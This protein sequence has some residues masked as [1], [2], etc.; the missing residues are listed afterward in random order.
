MPYE[1]LYTSAP[2]GLKPGSSGYCT[3][4]SSRGIPA[5]AVDLLESLSG[6]RHV[7]TPGSPEA[8]RN[9]VNWG[10]YLLRIS[11]RTEHVLSRVSDCELDYT[12]RSNKLA[13]HMVIDATCPA[14]PA[15][16]VGQPGW[17]IGQWD[18]QLEQFATQRKAPMERRPAGRCAAWEAA[19]GDAGWGGVLAESFLADP[20][21]KVFLIYR[22]D[23][24]ILPLIEEAIALLP[25][26]R[27]WDVTFATYGAA[28]P[29]TVECAWTGVV[30]G[31]PEVQQSH[32]FVNALRIDLTT[33]VPK[34]AGGALVE[35][36]RSGIRPRPTSAVRRPD[37][38]QRDVPALPQ[39]S[40]SPPPVKYVLE[41]EPFD[42][43]LE[44][45]SELPPSL[46]SRKV[47]GSGLSLA[48]VVAAVTIC[49]LTSIAAGFWLVRTRMNW[50]AAD[51]EVAQAAPLK[52]ERESEGTGQP[53]SKLPDE[54]ADDTGVPMPAQGTGAPPA[55]P[56]SE[57]DVN[58][59][60][61]SNGANRAA[62]NTDKSPPGKAMAVTPDSPMEDD[63][64]QSGPHV[65]EIVTQHRPD[66]RSKLREPTQFRFVAKKPFRFDELSQVSVLIPRGQGS[67]DKTSNFHSI[68]GQTFDGKKFELKGKKGNR[69]S[70]MEGT[71]SIDKKDGVVLTLTP[72]VDNLNRAHLVCLAN[73]VVQLV[74]KAGNH[75]LLQLTRE[76]NDQ[77]KVTV[78]NGLMHLTT[79]G[80][81]SQL[82]AVIDESDVVIDELS[83]SLDSKALKPTGDDKD[84]FRWDAADL[85]D[86]LVKEI[87]FAKQVSADGQGDV[88]VKWTNYS[89]LKSLEDPLANEAATLVLA[90]GPIKTDVGTSSKALLA[91]EPTYDLDATPEAISDAAKQVEKS[92][93]AAWSGKRD[94]KEITEEEY[95]RKLPENRSKFG[96]YVDKLQDYRRRA[97]I[98][99]V[100]KTRLKVDSGRLRYKVHPLDTD[101]RGE[102]VASPPSDQK[103]LLV[104]LLSFGQRH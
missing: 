87:V 24:N 2:S 15:W 20:E 70:Q 91:L 50:P 69:Q 9:P 77:S 71:V 56:P 19:T 89:E 11:G 18:G 88:F 59:R 86:G 8:G 80:A 1:I 10:H 28:L 84:V 98:V 26:N 63:K 30:A 95:K 60:T 49:L 65:T 22:P 27:Q 44:Y 40:A 36:A 14:G 29:K 42:G 75:L 17:M 61:N 5:P 41:S 62:S 99:H 55:E 58:D 31:S 90:L 38:P 97:K 103:F 93:E 100:V 16:L 35:F 104:N 54:P 101:L 83:L 6:Y 94:R 4:K 82:L 68:V 47:K 64:N 102:N 96:E 34:A 73:G 32:R 21:R 52:V 81:T 23:Q 37:A 43:E 72:T 48:I 66:L 53:T 46:P 12:G 39:Q 33:P 51:I 74:D 7:F 45:E 79:S 85:T 76:V 3:V 92:L 57:P 78:N 25:E 13:H 67:S